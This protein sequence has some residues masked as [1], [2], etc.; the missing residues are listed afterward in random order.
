ME[1]PAPRQ[2]KPDWF[3]VPANSGAANEEVIRLIRSL[4]L[5]TVCEEANCPNAGECFSRQ[6]ATFMLLGSQCTRRCTFCAVGKGLPE[7]PDPEEPAR[8]AEAISQLKLKHVVLT[9]VTRDDLPDGGAQHFAEV[10]QAIRAKIPEQTPAIEVLISD[11]QGNWDALDVIIAASPEVINHNV[12]TV[13]R[14]YPTVRPQAIFA[15]SVELLRR[16]KQKR[17][18]ILTKSGIMVGL[19]ETSDEVLAVMQELRAA[20]CDLLTIGQYLSPS[21][22]HHPV[23]EY[24]HP[25]QFKA[26]S[27]AGLALGFRHVASGPLVRSSYHAGEAFDQTQKCP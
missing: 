1:Q 11:L 27:E 2:R 12:E 25:D 10:I 6:T 24:I 26:Y 14:L 21:K 9:T 13:P 17:P 4:N 19:G 23:V 7:Q 5:H 8:L 18:D 3:K 20:G 15:R 16:V 22:L